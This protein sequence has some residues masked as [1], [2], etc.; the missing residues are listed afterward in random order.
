MRSN[1]S[2]SDFENGWFAGAG[3]DMPTPF[4]IPNTFMQVE[5]SHADYGSSQVALAGTTTMGR[6]EKT[7]DEV[8]FGFKYFFPVASPVAVGSLK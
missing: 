2:T 1:V 7:T 3:V 8:R 5:Y 6:I 4:L